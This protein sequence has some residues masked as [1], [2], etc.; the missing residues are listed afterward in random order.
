VLNW[1]DRMVGWYH[2][3]SQCMTQ[4][5]SSVDQRKLKLMS[6]IKTTEDMRR[7]QQQRWTSSIDEAGDSQ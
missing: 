2:W 1:S 5:L 6:S 4:C 7:L 3:L